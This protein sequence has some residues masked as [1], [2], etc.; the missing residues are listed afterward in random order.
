MDRAARGVLP[1][2]RSAL[3]Q[4][5]F[6]LEGLEVDAQAMRRNIDLTGGLVMSEAVMM[7]LGPY[8]GREY[9]HDLVYDICR[10]AV[11]PA[12][13]AA[14]SAGCPSRDQQAPGP[15]RPG[16]VVRS[17]ELP[18]AVGCDGR[19]GAG[20]PAL[21]PTQRPPQEDTVRRR[22]TSPSGLHFG[23]ELVQLL[24]SGRERSALAADEPDAPR[25]DGVRQRH[26]HQQR[27]I[28]APAWPATAPQR[29][30][31]PPRPDRAWW[32]HAAPRG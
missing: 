6:V 16:E 20:Q 17:G 11:K 7:G 5:R 8:I 14:R 31:D 1:H 32:S 4:S 18:G 23:Q 22:R 19:S 29:P 28:L 21:R 10:E 25:H 15:R 9:A 3:K 24:C 26:A 27:V 30:R 12:A 13:A 2:G